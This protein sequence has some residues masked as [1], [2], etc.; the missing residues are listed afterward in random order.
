LLKPIKNNVIV[1]LIEK[2][3]V[4]SSGIVLSSADPV[5]ANRAK[6]IFLGPDVETVQK[7]DFV[8]PNWNSARKTKYDGTDYYIVSEEEIVLIFGD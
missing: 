5:E 8:L 6:V 7:G 4:T 1:E 2:E 3:K